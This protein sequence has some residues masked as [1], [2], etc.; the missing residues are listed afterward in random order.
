[1]DWEDV[2]EEVCTKLEIGMSQGETELDTVTRL[3]WIERQ[4]NLDAIEEAIATALR[5]ER[6]MVPRTATLLQWRPRLRT[7]GPF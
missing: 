7:R 3:V 6:G 5:R 2:R 4:G 1:M